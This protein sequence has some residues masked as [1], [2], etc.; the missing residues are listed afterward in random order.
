MVSKHLQA[1]RLGW[2]GLGDGGTG[3]RRRESQRGDAGFEVG[4]EQKRPAAADGVIEMKEKGWV[5]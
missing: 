3:G 5:L 2:A 4:G 1:S